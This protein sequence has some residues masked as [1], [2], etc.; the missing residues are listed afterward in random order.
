MAARLRHPWIALGS[1]AA[2]AAATAVAAYAAGSVPN[3]TGARATPATFCAKSSSGCA[4]PGTTIRFH[5]STPA[6]VIGDIRPRKTEIWGYR[7][8]S[9]RFPAGANAVHVNDSRLTTGR[10]QF[11]LQGINSVGASGPTLINL[12]VVKKR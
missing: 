7:E 10:W 3:F 4:H 8:F 6:K 12:R 5:L 2:V 1:A 9:R 11:R